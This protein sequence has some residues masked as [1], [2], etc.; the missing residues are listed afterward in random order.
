M[1][2]LA[3]V[4]RTCEKHSFIWSVW[5]HFFTRFWDV[6]CPKYVI[7]DGLSPSFPDFVVTEPDPMW[8]T[9]INNWSRISVNGVEQIPH[10]NIFWVLDDFVFLKN[11]SREFE[12]LYQIFCGMNADSLRILPVYN[13]NKFKFRE[14]GISVMDVPLRWVDDDFPYLVTYMPVI[15][16]KGFLLECLSGQSNPWNAERKGSNKI[17]NKQKKLLHY[18][19]DSWA[20]GIVRRGKLTP[21]GENIIKQ[22]ER[23]KRDIKCL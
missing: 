3:L 1:D 6:D 10:E 13:E 15:L 21:S 4:Y 17:R 20:D 2:N 16:K 18:F 22:I 8:G 23:D 12:L 14:T 19:I 9:G 7:S 5:H 11:I